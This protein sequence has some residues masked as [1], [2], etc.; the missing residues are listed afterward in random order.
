MSESEKVPVQSLSTV[1]EQVR[2]QKMFYKTGA[3]RPLE[4]RVAML[5]KLAT[6]IRENEEKILIALKSDLNKSNQEAYTTEVG[7]LLEEIR[8]TIKHLE[9]WMKP[10]KVKTAK[11]HIGSKGYKIAEPY[12]VA[13][14]IAPWNYPFQLAL[15]PLIGAI[16]A[17]N[18]AII[19][20]SE[21][22]P[23]TSQL[24]AQMIQDSFDSQCLHVMEGGVETTQ[25]LLKQSFDYIFF[26]GSV[27]VG[28]I[29]MEAASKQ[30][31][32]I[33]LELGGK[34]PCIVD[35]SANISLAAKR[36]AFGKLINSGQT[37]IAPDYLFIHKKVKSLF[38]E[39]FKKVVTEFYGQD[40]IGNEAYGRIVNHKHFECLK[41]YLGDGKILFGG[42]LN[43]RELKV[44]PTIMEPRSSNV[45]VM[46]EEIFGPILPLLDFEDL[47]EV[48][49]YVTERPK[50]L[51]LYVFTTSED[52]E[53]KVNSTISF[54]GGCVNDT[55]MH[56]ATPYLPFGGVGESGIGSYHGK[57]SFSTFSH[58]KS[59]LKQT[60]KFDFHF[61]YPNAKN[62]MKIMKKLMK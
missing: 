23:H 15:S 33:T 31:I 48:I 61:R 21:L 6:L 27:P 55:L 18:T 9:K 10:E 19:K 3:T 62:G 44:E 45:P 47:Q 4:Y 17:G 7:I 25:N 24:L 26:T 14:I 60:N 58:Y 37:C 36:I 35:E 56:I 39:E 11:T 28:K 13:L 52:I 20:P 51:A 22:T 43:E 32:P 2:K 46:Q 1:K 38:L 42:N 34:S 41:N 29:V 53:E 16:A 59:V 57:S 50:P 54:G 5:N 8:Y 12:G 30:L 49:D 40:P